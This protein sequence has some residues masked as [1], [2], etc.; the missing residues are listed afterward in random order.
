LPA[1]DLGVP[2]ERVTYQNGDVFDSSA[3]DKKRAWAELATIAHRYIHRL[4]PDM[5]PGL[6]VSHIMPC[7]WAAVCH[8]RCRV[9]MYPCYSFEF[10][11][12]L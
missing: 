10:H 9:Q 8:G 11:L 6:S 7:R 3:P 2:A 12:M 4:P 1:H 5:E